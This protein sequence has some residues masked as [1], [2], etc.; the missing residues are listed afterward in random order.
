MTRA[1][2]E[3]HLIR[4]YGGVFFDEFSDLNPKEKECAQI[5]RHICGCEA[6]SWMK[7]IVAGYA[8]TTQDLLSTVGEHRLVSVTGRQHT[9]EQMIHER[10]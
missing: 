5:L 8:L 1:N 6:T 9:L 7:I 2:Q 4:R 3:E 10:A